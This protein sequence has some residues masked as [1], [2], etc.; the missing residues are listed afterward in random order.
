ME[1]LIPEPKNRSTRWIST[2]IPESEWASSPFAQQSSAA[3]HENNLLAPVLFHEAV[4][5]I[6]KNAI[7]IEIAPTGL[8]QG[9]LKRSLSPTAISLGLMKRGHENNLAFFLENI[10]K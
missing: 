3:Y 5:H 1:C 7:C 4:Q 2:S 6:P 9:I 8:L 10:G